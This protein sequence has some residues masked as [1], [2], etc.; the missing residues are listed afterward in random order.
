MDTP[1]LDAEVLLSAVLG[2]PRIHLYVHFDQP[3]VPEELARYRALVKQRAAHVPV[4]YI[5]GEK[6]FMG[7]TFK[8]TEATLIPRPDTEI[9]VETVTAYRLLLLT[10]VRAQAPSAYR[11][12]PF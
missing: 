4:A 11:C 6:E 3:L 9:L 1:R 10:L 12:F 8:V 7:L 2:Q 5:L